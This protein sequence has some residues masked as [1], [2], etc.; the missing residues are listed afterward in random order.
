MQSK[1][2]LGWLKKF[3]PAQNILGPVKGQGI[4]VQPMRKIFSNFVCF[5]ESPNF[6]VI[7]VMRL[8]TEK[9]SSKYVHMKKTKY[10]CLFRNNFNLT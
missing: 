9:T 1:Q 3:G 5:S 8:F 6:I 4:S 10:E 7:S 2:F